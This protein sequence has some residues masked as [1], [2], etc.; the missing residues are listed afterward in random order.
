M[1]SEISYILLKSLH[2]ICALATLS[3]F[4]WRCRTIFSGRDL[5]RLWLRHIPDSVDTILL[6]SGVVLMFMI[7]LS[8][9]AGGWISAKLLAVFVYIVLGTIALYFGRTM[10]VRRM[11]W[12]GALLVFAY[13]VWL[14]HFK[15]ILPLAG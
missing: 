1:P 14:A 13:I 9:L 5:S 7:G 15:E 12:A 8:P 10:E 3:L 6:G 4:I 2:V 11:A